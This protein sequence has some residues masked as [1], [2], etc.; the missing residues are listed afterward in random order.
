MNIAWD[1]FTPWSS[2]AGGVLIG[3]SAALL[4]LGSGR[5]AGISGIVGGL[6][7]PGGPDTRWRLAFLGGLL[8]APL[9]WRLFAA[10]PE[11]QPVTGGGMLVVAGLLVGIGT[12]YGSGCTS[13]HGVCGLSRLS[14]RS[15]AA[16]LTFMG[17]GFATVYV[18]RHLLGA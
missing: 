7:K 5:V 14:P 1:A 3:L 16:T 6:L 15:L 9:L 18:V 17:A 12:R 2:L 10:L 4:I 8:A 13:G 11:A